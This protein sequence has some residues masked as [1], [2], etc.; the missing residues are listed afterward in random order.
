M[1][2]PV[3]F[4]ENYFLQSKLAYLQ[5]IGQTQYTSTLQVYNAIIAAGQTPFDNFQM[6]SLEER[7]SPN[8]YFSTTEYLEAKAAALNAASYGGK[9]DWT[10]DAVALEFSKAGFGNAYAH[11]TAVGW[12]E[13]VNPSNSFDTDLYLQEKANEL[14]AQSYEGKT[15]WTADDVKAAFKAAGIDPIEHYE[16]AGKSEGLTAPEVPDADKVTPDSG[17]G[18]TFTLTTAPDTIPGLVGSEGTTSTS[19][20]DTIGAV[21]DE[22]GTTSTLNLADSINA[23]TGTN[24]LDLRYTDSTGAGATTITAAS[25]P[26]LTN[27]QVLNLTPL[28]NATANL[29]GIAPDLTTINVKNPVGTTAIS[30]A[31]IA[32]NTFGIDTVQQNNADIAIT[33]ASGLTGSSDTVALNVMG[34]SAAATNT[35]GNFAQFDLT[36]A[37]A[38]DGVDIIN[39]NATG[40]NSR[41]DTLTAEDSA[42][43]STLTTVNIGGTAGFRVNTALANSVTKIDAAQNSGGVN[44]GVAAGKDVTFTGGSGNDRINMAGGLTTGDSLNGGTGTNTLAVNDNTITA[45]ADVTPINAVT[46]FQVLEVTAAVTSAGNRIQTKASLL[47]N[48]PTIGFSGGDGGLSAGSGA[49]V[50]SVTVTGLA[51][52]NVLNISADYKGQVGASSASAAGSAGGDAFDVTPT[53]NGPA[54][55]VGIALKGGVDLAGGA[56]GASTNAGSMGGAGGH[57]I[58][59]TQYETVNLDSSGTTAN[60]LA[61]GAGGAGTASAFNGA[62]GAGILVNT[63]AVI[64]VTGS[65]NLT[66]TTQSADPTT[67]GVQVK[68]STFMGKLNVTGTTGADAITGGTGDDDITAGAGVDTIDL[69]AGGQDTVRLGNV[70]VTTFANN[71]A[72]RDIISGFTAG[73]GGDILDTQWTA[74]LTPITG[75]GVAF[76][77]GTNNAIQA[78]NFAATNN[79]ANLGSVTDGTELLKGIANQGSVINSIG[80]GAN[81]TGYIVAYDGTNGYLYAYD[82]ANG[83]AGIVAAEIALVGTLNGID[84]GSLV[85]GNFT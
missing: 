24:S 32:V 43:T 73:S 37:A 10:A 17:T 74:F 9:T 22:K 52:T 77:I 35:A 21:F 65:Q 44:V 3:W 36:G 47:T 23:G 69:T 31:P 7:T 39:V 55:I 68:A 49:G 58:N 60:T 53:T 42:A 67:G 28:V 11:Y 75:S 6:Y 34:A 14:N 50:D 48:M 64:N 72:N 82:D 80:V 13:G 51:D 19:G 71:A 83:D 4:D 29:T 81:D 45:T 1:A 12:D 33:H 40:A 57:G 41:L 59:A 26:V 70:D 54:N 76:N 85:A 61:G 56:G 25:T 16:A 15:D 27:V 62:A 8:Q 20:D 5:S 2:N 78:F 18:Q 46:N 38:G 30:G 84:T 66:M 79:S 63:N